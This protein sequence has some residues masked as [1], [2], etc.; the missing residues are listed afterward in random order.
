V[1]GVVVLIL[2]GVVRATTGGN[3]AG[4]AGIGTGH[5]RTQQ[6]PSSATFGESQNDS[7]G[8]DGRSW[9]SGSSGALSEKGSTELDP[10]NDDERSVGDGWAVSLLAKVIGP[11]GD[12]RG[13]APNSVFVP[14]EEAS[15]QIRVY[16]SKD[17]RV[18]YG[19]YNGHLAFVTA[20]VEGAFEAADQEI[21]SKYSSGTQVSK[22]S[23]GDGKA[24]GI[25]EGYN[26][27]GKLYKRGDTNTRI[28]LLQLQQEDGAPGRGWLLYI[29]NAYLLA[30]R[31]D[32]WAKF[33]E[34]GQEA[35][36]KRSVEEAAEREK[37]KRSIQ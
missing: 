20:D 14:S 19:F 32:W 1:A 11:P 33:N 24:P 25:W 36:R 22:D 2:I 13:D 34:V 9:G 28:Y 27:A 4:V 30:I 29:P 5:D 16:P 10:S 37:D 31:N 12:I 23:S 7:E 15:P 35:A 26:F 8:Y 17:Q 3:S 6:Q 18:E 21:E